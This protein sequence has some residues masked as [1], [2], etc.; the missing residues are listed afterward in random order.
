MTGGPHQHL[1]RLCSC[2]VAHPDGEHVAAQ[3]L[4]QGLRRALC[5]HTTLIDDHHTISQAIG[6]L[7]VLR[8]EHD[9]R[10]RCCQGGHRLPE[11][12]AAGRVQPGGR[13]IKEQ[14]RRLRDQRRGQVQATTLPTGV[15]ADQ[16]V[17]ERAQVQLGDELLGPLLRPTAGQLVEPGEQGEILPAGQLLIDSR[18]LSG[19]ADQLPDHVRL[20]LHIESQDAGFPGLGFQHGGEHM[21]GGALARPVRPQDREHLSGA[22]LETHV[23][24]RCHIPERLRKLPGEDDG[25]PGGSHLY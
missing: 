5:D 9:R 17:D 16:A 22:D 18:T 1:G 7:E 24:H 13:F 8:G 2:V 15:G 25:G 19:H 11:I 21:N 12:G 3:L 4:L 14:G 6:L 20:A 23:H 10:P